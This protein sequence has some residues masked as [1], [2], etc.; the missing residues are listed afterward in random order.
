VLGTIQPSSCSCSDFS[1]SEK[2]GVSINKE[3]VNRKKQD[4]LQIGDW[5]VNEWPPEQIIQYY[6]PATRGEDGSWG[7][8]TPICMLNCIIWLWAVVEIITNETAKALNILAKQQTKICNAIYQ[9]Y[10]ALDS[11]LAS[12]GGVCGK[13]S[14]SNCY[15]QI[16]DEGKVIEEITD[17]MKNLLMSLCRPGR[18]GAPMTCSGLVLNPRCIQ[19]LNGQRSLS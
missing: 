14:L 5:K 8:C 16:D 13:F 15:L 11:L 1:C 19:D 10:L 4:A 18:D 7:Y 3:R 12:E 2:L 6:G 17:K 9:N